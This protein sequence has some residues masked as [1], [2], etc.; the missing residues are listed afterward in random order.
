MNNLIDLFTDRR[1]FS[2]NFSVCI[3]DN[4]QAILLYSFGSFFVSFKTILFE[5]LR[6]VYFDNQL[7]RCTVKIYNISID[8]ALF[9]KFYGVFS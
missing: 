7:G 1:K 3:A 4:L 8:Y 9:V 5:M 2:V 6:T